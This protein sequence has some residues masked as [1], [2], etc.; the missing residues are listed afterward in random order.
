MAANSTEIL[1]DFPPIIRIY[2]DGRVERLTGE[3]IVPASVD[4]ETGVQ[5]KDI[6]ISPEF[7][8]SARLYLPGTTNPGR[9]LPLLVYF[10]GGAFMVESPFSPSHHNHMNSLVAEA[11]VVVV[12]VGY[13]LAPEH[14][15]PI[16]YEDSWLALKWVASQSTGDGHEP[17]IQ[18]NA[19][20]DRVY[21]G[22]DSAGA[23]IAHNMA[24]RFGLDKLGGINLDGIFLI[25][26]YFWG[27]DPIGN[28][29][30]GSVVPK[31][32]VD[33]L[34]V[35]SC[36]NTTG[37]DDPLINPSMDL[38]LSKL[39]CKK[40]LIYVAEYDLLK[41]RGYYYKESLMNCGWGGDV[42]IVEAKGENHV[43]SVFSPN[44]EN[45]KA[46]FK[47]IALFMNK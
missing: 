43:F 27:K 41:E 31:S 42:D 38:N 10:H 16:A 7:D 18:E 35:F 40:V 19:D 34:W 45:G 25:C 24:I 37:L 1:H 30:S 8:I 4:S 6:Q 32:Y 11:N 12:S 28:E 21:L 26:P 23:N 46:M 15:L 13:R 29:N 5:S 39:G 9:K 14:P 44:G 2:K 36:P 22:G 47:R 33:N 20:F 3:D 17:W